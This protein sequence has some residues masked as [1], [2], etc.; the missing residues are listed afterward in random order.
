M[1]LSETRRIK[2]RKP[3]EQPCA[4]DGGHKPHTLPQASCDSGSQCAPCTMRAARLDPLVTPAFALPRREME[5]VD[6]IIAIRMPAL[7]QQRNAPRQ[8]SIFA[9]QSLKLRQI[10][11]S[12]SCKPHK[13]AKRG[14]S[15][16]IRQ[17]SAARR[18]HDG[19][20]YDW[21]RQFRQTVRHRMRSLGIA[22]HTDF[23]CVHANVADDGA[24]LIHDHLR[25]NHVHRIDP[26]RILRGNRG[27]R[28]HCMPPKHGD[29]FNVRLNSRPAAAV[30][31]SDNQNAS[32]SA[33]VHQDAAALTASHML[34]TM[35][36]T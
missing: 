27:D 20:E 17:H 6:H 25:R 22:N 11:R 30:G 21:A 8:Q 14:D 16:R 28:R 4:C 31:A 33:F 7:N 10:G 13:P 35:R 3:H 26:K 1:P 23:D 29:G 32:G 18:D 24:D 34:S 2:Q 12:Q 36:S 15:I 19:I 9:A 5:F